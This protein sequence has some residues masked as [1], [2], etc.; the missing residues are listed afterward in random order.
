[1]SGRVGRFFQELFSM[2]LWNSRLYC[3]QYSRK[4]KWTSS[5]LLCPAVF[6]LAALGTRLGKGE[7]PP[8]SSQ[9]MATTARSTVRAFRNKEPCIPVRESVGKEQL[10][11]IGHKHPMNSTWAAPRAGL[12]EALTPSTTT[13]PRNKGTRHSKLGRCIHSCLLLAHHTPFS[14]LLA[15]MFMHIRKKKKEKKSVCSSWDAA[16]ICDEFCHGFFYLYFQCT[17]FQNRQIN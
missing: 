12:A 17:H 10:D 2:T 16:Q 15:L 5:A 11:R 6:R 4:P 13:P 1:M 14:I 7:I 8:G 3:I 9:E